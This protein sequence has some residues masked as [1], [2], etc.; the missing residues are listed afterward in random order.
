[1]N[2]KA[3]TAAALTGVLRPLL[4]TVNMV[5]APEVAKE[6]GIVIEDVRREQH[7]AYEN[8]IRLTVITERQERSVAGTV[9]GDQKPRIIQIKGINM[10][11]ELGE[12]MLYVTNQD[13][14]GFIGQLGSILGDAKINIATFNLGR[15][16]EGEEAICLVEIDGAISEETVNEIAAIEQVKQ[17]KLLHFTQ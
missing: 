8:Y 3:M 13:K 17:A 6:R 12:N 11:A 10:E 4:Q 7:G 5:S 16:V 15:K 14:P 1:M 2:V 9:F